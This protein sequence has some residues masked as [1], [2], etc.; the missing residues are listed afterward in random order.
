MHD[1]VKAVSITAF[2]PALIEYPYSL[3]PYSFAIGIPFLNSLFLIIIALLALATPPAIINKRVSKSISLFPFID[4]KA[5]ARN[6][7]VSK[8][9]ETPEP[10]AP[11]YPKATSLSLSLL[12]EVLA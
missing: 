9:I 1:L 5:F 8:I 12:F 4:F 6:V 2:W 11:A 3:S 10:I 7:L